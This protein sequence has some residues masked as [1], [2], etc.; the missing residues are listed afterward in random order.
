[1][2]EDYERQTNLI[3]TVLET[4]NR[5]QAELDNGVDIENAFLVTFRKYQNITTLT[6]E[7]LVELI[8]HI[9]VYENG[10]ISVKFN[11]ADEYRRV[12]EYIEANTH[13]AVG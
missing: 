3:Q 8:D 10:N 6:R 12:V 5:E 1:M 2:S 13:K 4:L 7:L 9:K 11:F